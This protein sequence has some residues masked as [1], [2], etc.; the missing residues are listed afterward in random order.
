M[1][2]DAKHLRFL[3]HV[4]YEA[5]V[6]FEADAL[7]RAEIFVYNKVTYEFIKSHNPQLSTRYFSP[8]LHPVNLVAMIY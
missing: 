2:S 4:A 8:L 1:S 7:R 3:G 5:R 6:Y